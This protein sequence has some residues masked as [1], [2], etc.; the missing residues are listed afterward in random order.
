[1]IIQS[2]TLDTED[3]VIA[4]YGG[5]SWSKIEGRFLLGASSSYAV[6]STGGEATHK[7]TTAEMPSHSHNNVTWSNN[8]KIGSIGNNY[9]ATQTAAGYANRL[10]AYGG[11]VNGTTITN[12]TGGNTAH[13]NMPPYVALYFWERTA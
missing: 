5:T 7:L 11:D 1:M 12:S 13:N 8:E 4:I 3:K 6:N 9:G 2:T 10:M